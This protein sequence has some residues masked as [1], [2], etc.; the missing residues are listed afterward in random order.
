MGTMSHD[1][2]AL[3][4]LALAAVRVISDLLSFGFLST[5]DKVRQGRDTSVT[6]KKGRERCTVGVR[7]K[8]SAFQLV[9]LF[10]R[11]SKVFRCTDLV[12]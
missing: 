1:Q 2:R 7:A 3:N 9:P 11:S 5:Y 10:V 6:K 4:D 12:P 8:T